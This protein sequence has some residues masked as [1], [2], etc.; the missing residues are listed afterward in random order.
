MVGID[1]WSP[2]NQSSVV[3]SSQVMRR[4][5][6]TKAELDAVGALYM[7]F[8]MGVLP[9]INLAFG[10]DSVPYVPSLLLP[11]QFQTVRPLHISTVLTNSAPSSANVKKKCST[12]SL[13]STGQARRFAAVPHLGIPRP[14]SHRCVR[15]VERS[16]GETSRFRSSCR[17]YV[18]KNGCIRERAARV[19]FQRSRGTNQKCLTGW[20]IQFASA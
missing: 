16:C 14:V 4:L 15:G 17:Q 2:L 10:A 7:G 12:F 1:D 8:L 5:L 13:D 9:E 11:D 18:E 19:F 6:A 3:N 20:L